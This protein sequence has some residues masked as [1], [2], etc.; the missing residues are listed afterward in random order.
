[1]EE[2]TVMIKEISFLAQD[3]FRYFEAYMEMNTDIQFLP[4]ILPLL[5]SYEVCSISL[6]FT[7]FMP[8]GA[9][10]TKEHIIPD[11]SWH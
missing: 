9:R 7:S 10:H 8:G 3:V 11:N 2:E 1:M 4:F 6:K 5:Q